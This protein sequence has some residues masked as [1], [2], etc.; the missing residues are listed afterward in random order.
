MIDGIVSCSCANGMR[1]FPSAL[2]LIRKCAICHDTK[3]DGIATKQFSVTM[4][5]P[6]PPH[7]DE[8]LGIVTTI[9]TTASAYD[10]KLHA[11]I[12]QATELIDDG[13][14]DDPAT[15]VHIVVAVPSI[16]A[17]LCLCIVGCMCMSSR[18]RYICGCCMLFNDKGSEPD[19]AIGEHQDE[20]AETDSV[21]ESSRTDFDTALDNEESAVR[22]SSTSQREC[23]RKVATALENGALGDE[24][25]ET[26]PSSNLS[27][28]MKGK[29]TKKH[30]RLSSKGD[31]VLD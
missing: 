23:C 19:T 18:V 26:A 15:A 20:L 6:S 10:A 30:A 27:P 25:V 5:P 28:K 7:T 21:D 12:Q 31:D 2:L 1:R 29:Q 3:N 17:L 14:M 13:S 11:L 24:R 4:A 9:A 16:I 22:N 8:S